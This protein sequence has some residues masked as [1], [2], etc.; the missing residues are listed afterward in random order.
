M[1][2]NENKNRRRKKKRATNEACYFK[3]IMQYG[4]NTKNNSLKACSQ[5]WLELANTE[6]KH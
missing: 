4:N 1:T 5:I 3:N 2:Q 6:L